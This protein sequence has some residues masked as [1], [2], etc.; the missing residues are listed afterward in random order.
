VWNPERSSSKEKGMSDVQGQSTGAGAPPEQPQYP[1]PVQHAGSGPSGP[2]A[3]FG[4]RLLALIVDGLVFAIPAILVF[5]LFKPVVAYVLVWVGWAAY[6]VVLIGGPTGQTVG[7]R[8][9]GI[10]VVDFDTGGP[11]GHGR[12]FVRFLVQTFISGLI[13]YLGYL[14]MLWDREKQTW[15]DKA[16][17]SVVVPESAYPVQR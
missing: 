11:V 2:R 12:A 16:A 6:Y 4:L 10:R 14:W 8:A 15:H 13:V 9:L 3:N 5:V 7:K 1:P 17:N